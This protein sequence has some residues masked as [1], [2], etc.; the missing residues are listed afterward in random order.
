MKPDFLICREKVMAILEIQNQTKFYE[1]KDKGFIPPA[2]GQSKRTHLWSNTLIYDLKKELIK[3]GNQYSKKLMMDLSLNAFI[4]L[5]EG[6]TT[7]Y[8]A[9]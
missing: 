8:I 9:C 2:C 3:N 4:R 6:G 1:L 5:M 7:K